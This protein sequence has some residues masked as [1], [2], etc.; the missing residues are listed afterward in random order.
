MKKIVLMSVAVTCLTACASSG[1]IPTGNGAFLL[2]KQSAG[3]VFKA[4]ASVKADL[5]IE[6]NEFCAK[7][8][9]QIELISADSKNAIPF[10]RTSSAEIQFKC[11]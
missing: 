4:G 5:L 6:A 10:A 7:S 2:T 8:G 11:V 9:K 1:P 3:G